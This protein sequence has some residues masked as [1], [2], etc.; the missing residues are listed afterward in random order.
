MEE[1]ELGYLPVFHRGAI[2]VAGCVEE[3]KSGLFLAHTDVLHLSQT[4]GAI[5]AVRALQ[6]DIYCSTINLDT[7]VKC[8]RSSVE[9]VGFDFYRFLEHDT[10]RFRRTIR[11][12]KSARISMAQNL[13]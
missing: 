5:P 10:E 8:C 3:C 6:E 2:I 1:D 11:A 4:L 13:N 12:E 9:L 7:H